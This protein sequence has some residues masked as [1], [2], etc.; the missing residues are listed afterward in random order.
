MV[1]TAAVPVGLQDLKDRAQD[2]RDRLAT[3]GLAVSAL[4]RDAEDLLASIERDCLESQNAPSQE[5]TAARLAADQSGN[6]LQLE[7]E[8]GA[9]TGDCPSENIPT[10]GLLAPVLASPASPIPSTPATP[11]DDFSLIKGIDPATAEVLAGLGLST[12]AELANLYQEDVEE[13]G[14]ALSDPRRICREC[15]IE[16][17][18]ILASGH[19]TAYAR[20]LNC[21]E[22][23]PAAT[24]PAAMRASTAT[25]VDWAPC[26]APLQADL[27]PA[28]GPDFISTPARDAN[29]IEIDIEITR[30]KARVAVAAARRGTSRRVSSRSNAR[31]RTKSTTSTQHRSGLRAGWKVAMTTAAAIAL[32]VISGTIV[33][34]DALQRELAARLTRLGTCTVEAISTN[35]DCA[36]LAWLSL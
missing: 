14:T 29:D 12:F 26:F 9:P 5:I 1:M 23:A 28:A 34:N 13:I 7:T 2:F 17:A 31:A 6:D 21:A 20:T 19:T 24:E 18:A 22:P 32:A 10:D 11:Q 27:L 35:Q 25:L 15:W 3:L 33:A 30:A 8:V 36:I 16:Q 4:Q